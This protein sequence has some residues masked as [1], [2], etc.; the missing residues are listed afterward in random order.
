MK[1]SILL[2]SLLYFAL[3]AGA[4]ENVPAEKIIQKINNGQNVNYKDALITGVLDFTK[5]ENMECKNSGSNKQ[6]KSYIGVS[7]SFTACE[8]D[9]KVVGSD[10]D[11]DTKTSYHAIFHKAVSFTNCTFK[12][13]TDF[14]HTHF[15]NSIEFNN[16]VFEREADF[17][18]TGFK[19]QVSFI[20]T[21]F[22]GETDFQHT[23]F[24]MGVD[25]SNCKFN[26]DVDMEHTRFSGTVNFDNTEF[27]DKIDA[28][29]AKI[30]GQAFKTFLR[31]R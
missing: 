16:C 3:T 6:C 19:A 27:N 12:D 31:N 24:P 14:Q 22:E 11:K 30:N 13:E 18:H 17:Q 28:E 10:W 21:V 5:L 23:N 29:H 1:T 9:E 4:M 26:D 20:A 2:F 8:F 15:S 25:F 7:V